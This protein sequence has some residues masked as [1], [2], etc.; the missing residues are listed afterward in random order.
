MNLDMAF[1]AAAA[2]IDGMSVAVSWAIGLRRPR[3][4]VAA[5]TVVA[6]RS[7]EQVDSLA[8]RIQV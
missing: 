1:A 7:A 4:E 8:T 2:V 5:Q 3:P 6:M